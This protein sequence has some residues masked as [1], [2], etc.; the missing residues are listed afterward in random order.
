MIKLSALKNEDILIV[1]DCDHILDK[2]EFLREYDK[3][4]AQEVEVFVA[5]K[6]EPIH[7]S[8][9]KVLED[10]GYDEYD[11]WVNDVMDQ[12]TSDEI[13]IIEK[14]VNDAIGKNPTYSRGSVVDVLA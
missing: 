4:R 11:E 5:L 2:E 14:V 13:A 9:Q 6:D 8:L 3:N 7:F 10:L 1:S 12:L